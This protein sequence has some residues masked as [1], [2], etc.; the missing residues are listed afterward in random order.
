MVMLQMIEIAG[1]IL[2]KKKKTTTTKPK[3]IFQE[4]IAEMPF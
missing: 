4:E 3:H 2:C 1:L